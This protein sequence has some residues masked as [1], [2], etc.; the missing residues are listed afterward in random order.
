[1]SALVRLFLVFMI[2]FVSLG[3]GG[4]T[5]P[6]TATKRQRPAFRSRRRILTGR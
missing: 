6:S 2:V 4:G 3:C 5:E 1:M